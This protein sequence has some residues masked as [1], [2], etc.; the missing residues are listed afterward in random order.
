MK[1]RAIT[2]AVTVV[3]LGFLAVGPLIP[4]PIAVIYNG[5][6]SAPIGFYRMQIGPV[7]KGDLVLARLPSWAERLADERGYLPPNAPIIKRVVAAGGDFVCRFGRKISVNFDDVAEALKS[8]NK[9]RALPYWIGCWRL[10]QGQYFLLQEHPRSFD[11]RY[12][13]PI[14]GS[15]IIGRA[16]PTFQDANANSPD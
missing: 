8:D 14:D 6:A 9:G 11:S 16:V 13:G 4:T 3:G 10:E 5:S 1:Q 15:L 7:S 12:L 2:L